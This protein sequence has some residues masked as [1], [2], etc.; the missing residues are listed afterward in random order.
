MR[1]LLLGPLEVRS[2]R[3]VVGIGSRLQRALLGA[4]L[5]QRNNVVSVDELIDALWEQPPGSA[6]QSLLNHVRRLRL[7]LENNVIET[8]APGYRVRTRSLDLDLDRYRGLVER[9]R[10]EEDDLRKAQLL[11]KADALWRGDVLSDVMLFGSCASAVEALNAER[12]E[13]LE[14]RVEAELAAGRHLELTAELE[15]LV[16][17]YPLRE[18]LLEQLMLALY[19]S[20]RQADALEAYRVARRRLVDEV[21]LDPG[22]AVVR[23]ERAILAH[24]LPFSPRTRRDAAPA[25]L[26]KTIE[27]A[28]GTYAEKADYAFRLGTAL[29]LMG[30]QELATEAFEEAS[31][32]AEL[33]GAPHLFLRARLELDPERLFRQGAT[34]AEILA[35][36]DD[37]VG[38]LEKVEDDLG[39]ALALRMRGAVRRDL[40]RVDE[41]LADFRDAAARS[42][43][44]VGRSWPTGL[45]LAHEGEALFLGTTPV[46]EA[47]GRCDAILD[48]IPWGP[49]GPWGLYCSLG[50]LHAMRGEFAPAR[51]Y[52][53]RAA[54]ACEEYGLI[55]RATWV[56]L[57]EASVEMLADELEAAELAL[58]TARSQIRA[59]PP[60]EEERVVAARHAR[61]LALL[62]HCDDAIDAA[63][64]AASSCNDDVG[65]RNEWLRAKALS[66][67]TDDPTQALPIAQ[68]AERILGGTDLVSLQG[69]TLLDLARVQALAG[70]VEDARI[71][72]A[73]AQA[74]FERKGHLVGAERAARFDYRSR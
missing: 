47:I 4:L 20:G 44:A 37:L 43:R 52:V 49:P 39:S 14:E 2:R 42:R 67:A 66:R 9:G 3:G 41:A 26:A 10:R 40:G 51:A 57:C 24:D 27:L 23:L 72:V 45:I 22:E 16:G 19:R 62:G 38:E 63:M 29:K 74:L 11:R 18:R 46:L 58:R 53:A 68:D 50:M 31:E 8:I 36:L 12:L 25:V 64:F 54:A 61:V 13:T 21:G 6:H 69:E 17:R 5:L 32:R 55:A 7:L 56:S 60:V 28:P 33:A 1:F 35:V 48:S 73:H 71:S 30:E 34:R 59:A 15:R 65:V 70:F